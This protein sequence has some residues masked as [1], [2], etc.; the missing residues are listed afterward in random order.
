MGEQ[1]WRRDIQG[2]NYTEQ[3]KTHGEFYKGIIDTLNRKDGTY[4]VNY[5]ANMMTSPYV[6]STLDYH[7]K[8]FDNSLHPRARGA[9]NNSEFGAW[10]GQACPIRTKRFLFCAMNL[11]ARAAWAQCRNEYRA[12]KVVSEGIGD[13]YLDLT[14]D[15]MFRWGYRANEVGAGVGENGTALDGLNGGQYRMA[16]RT[17]QF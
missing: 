15:H 14:S 11:N 8:T 1:F 12:M 6:S 16:G 10:G 4:A 17:A 5:G 9:R 7:M 13:Y 2:A 3:F